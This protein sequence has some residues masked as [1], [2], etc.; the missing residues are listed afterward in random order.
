VNVLRGWTPILARRAV[1]AAAVVCLVAGVAG[2][3]SGQQARRV[4]VRPARAG[5][6]LGPLEYN[7]GSS[8]VWLSDTT[9]AITDATEHQIVVFD[10][11]GREIARLGRSGRGPGEFAGGGVLLASDRG[12]I[13]VSDTRLSRVSYFDVRFRFVRSVQ[14]PGMPT[15]L[16]AWRGSRV[17][18][19]WSTVGTTGGGPVAGVVDLESGT[20]G[21]RFSV[22]RSDSV[23]GRPVSVG[24]M[25]LQLPFVSAVAARDGLYL[26]A[27]GDQYR[28]VGM[29]T[30]GVVRR[31][32][33]RPELPPEY[34]TPAERQADEERALRAQQRGGFNPPP[35][36]AR[37][38]RDMLQ[39]L[40]S[41]PK[42]YLTSALA[43]DRTGRV[44]VASDRGAGD[45]TEI[46]VFSER[47][48]FLQTV[49][50]PHRV[51]AMS[52]RQARLAV[53]AQHRGGPYDGQREVS[54]YVVSD[55]EGRPQRGRRE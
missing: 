30:A 2:P 45:S 14:L 18:V 5:P 51:A 20:V 37:M 4:E 13:V 33:G 26:F 32:F 12:E 54:V 40:L 55:G 44:W 52:F 21:A 28:F 49:V 50:V 46:D 11:S 39:E 42:D 19:V 15:A 53:L 6:T 8:V 24:G 9:L 7:A 48:E 41:R 38:L 23:L 36:A 17:A 47:G 10:T 29:D 43:V 16:L 27:R 35:E 3:L 1:P 22:F 25:T 31:T 34:R